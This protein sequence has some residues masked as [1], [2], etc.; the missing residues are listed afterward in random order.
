M[1]EHETPEPESVKLFEGMS[2]SDSGNIPTYDVTIRVR[3]YN[4]EV[5]DKA[6]WDDFNLTM[7]RTS[8]LRAR[9]LWVGCDAHQ[10][11]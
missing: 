1:A 7:Y 6:Y 3:R 10:R 11:T 5:S 9:Y 8:S 2:G 4:P